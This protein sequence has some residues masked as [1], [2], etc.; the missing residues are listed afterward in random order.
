[1][2]RKVCNDYVAKCL[3]DDMKSPCAHYLSSPGSCFWVAVD[4]S[5]GEVCG[6]VAVER[7]TAHGWAADGTDAELRRMSVASWARGAGVARLMFAELRRF[8]EKEKYR[9]IVLETS[10]LQRDAHNRLYPSLGFEA[11]RQKP[12]F[13]EVKSTAFALNL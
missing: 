6:T 10:T 12:V 2:P 5:S 7:A 4:A 11:M 3:A 13:G 1:M 8:C 9:R